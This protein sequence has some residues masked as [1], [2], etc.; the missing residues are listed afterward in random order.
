MFNTSTLISLG[1]TALLCGIIMFYCKRKFAEY[2]QKLDVMSD[3]I[4]NIITQ[5]NQIPPSVYDNTGLANEQPNIQMTMNSMTMPMAPAAYEESDADESEVEDEEEDEDNN[6]KEVEVNVDDSSNDK[7]IVVTLPNTFNDQVEN[8]EEQEE[9]DESWDSQ[10]EDDEEEEQS[11]KITIQ[12]HDMIITS[13]NL[14]HNEVKEE[15]KVE[16]VAEEVKEEV[17]ETEAKSEEKDEVVEVKS[18]VPEGEAKSE[19][20]SEEQDSETKIIDTTAPVDVDY[21]KMQVAMLKKMVAERNLA[22]GVSKMKKQELVNVLMNK[23]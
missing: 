11:H 21:N 23:P 20:K 12:P 6:I 4:S 9:D 17:A 14:D 7:R 5:L 15:A 13:V 18:E 2:E 1:L 10:E 16:E 19:E 8:N 3:L 22:Q